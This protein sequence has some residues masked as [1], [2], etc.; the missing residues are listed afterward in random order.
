LLAEFELDGCEGPGDVSVPVGL[1]LA[2]LEELEGGGE[3]G[4]LAAFSLNAAGVWELDGFTARTA[5]LLHRPPAS[6]KNHMGS[7][8]L[9][10]T[11]TVGKPGA[12]TGRLSGT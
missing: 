8:L 5:P 6:S 2:S 9:T 12:S 11:L 4:A 7:V 3:A 10:V 1:G